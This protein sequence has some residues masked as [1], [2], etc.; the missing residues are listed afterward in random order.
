LVAALAQSYRL[1]LAACPNPPKPPPVLVLVEM[2]FHRL[3]DTT[4]QFCVTQ[5][6]SELCPPILVVCWWASKDPEAHTNV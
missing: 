2:D 4:E 1:P 5:L 3:A 6:V